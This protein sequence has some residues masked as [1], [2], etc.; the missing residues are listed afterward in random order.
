MTEKIA[1][2]D[3]VEPDLTFTADTA[4]TK[5]AMPA[6]DGSPDARIWTVTGAG[7]Y[8][9]RILTA[10]PL[11]YVVRSREGHLGFVLAGVLVGVLTRH[12]VL[13]LKGVVRDIE[14]TVNIDHTIVATPAGGLEYDINAPSWEFA[15]KVGTKAWIVGRIDSGGNLNM[16]RTVTARYPLAA[17]DSPSF[18]AH[19][20]VDSGGDTHLSQ[21]RVQTVAQIVLQTL[22]EKPG[23]QTAWNSGSKFPASGVT[24]GG[25]GPAWSNPD[26]VTAFD[27]SRTV[28]DN[29]G[30]FGGDPSELLIATDFNFGA[31]TYFVPE[32]LLVNV[33]G[34]VQEVSSGGSAFKSIRLYHAGGEI[35]ND[36]GD[37]TVWAA[38]GVDAP[39][40][41][42]GEEDDWGAGLTAEMVGSSGFGLAL[43]VGGSS[44]H[45]Y[46][47][48][49]INAV[50]YG[51]IY[52]PIYNGQLQLREVKARAI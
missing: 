45:D 12:G 29:A 13:Y 15:V 34:S 8:G 10:G 50:L 44:A 39:R 11:N 21:D 32:G 37:L 6:A 48:D 18:G 41:F 17:G 9:E 24:G 49:S 2:P 7:I 40:F 5:A 4:Q 27:F 33:V 51:H 38:N 47:I 19:Y 1:T 52:E 35:G 25:V 30:G 14:R 23:S 42:G 26:R 43:S 31:P 46:Q 16:Y 3:D 28:A 22:V 20:V 36:K